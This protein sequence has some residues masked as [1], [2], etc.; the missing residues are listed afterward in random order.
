M[1]NWSERCVARENITHNSR[2]YSDECAFSVEHEYWLSVWN[3]T[4]RWISKNRQK[5][6]IFPY[7]CWLYRISIKINLFIFIFALECIMKRIFGCC[8][9]QQIENCWY[10]R[11]RWLP[12]LIQCICFHTISFLAFNF[13]AYNIIG[14]ARSVIQSY[15][16]PVEWHFFVAQ[17]NQ[18]SNVNEIN[19]LHLNGMNRTEHECVS[20]TGHMILAAYII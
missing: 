5:M 6:L 8:A 16:F 18:I 12:L 1:T 15:P 17:W 11:T 9:S 7:N 2:V 13:D 10:R 14:T 4:N 20:N 19:H 3:H